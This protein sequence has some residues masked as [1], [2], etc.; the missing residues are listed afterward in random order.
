MDFDELKYNFN[1]MSNDEKRTF[2][3][4]SSKE[5]ALFIVDFV[6][7]EHPQLLLMVALVGAA[8]GTDKAFSFWED[9]WK[10]TETPEYAHPTWFGFFIAEIGYRAETEAS[11]K[12]ELEAL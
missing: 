1:L 5:M 2:L 10:K 3:A 9:Y 7:K 8:T 4:E 11:F 12:K 6:Q